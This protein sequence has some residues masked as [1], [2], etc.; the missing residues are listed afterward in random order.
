L[1][2]IQEAL[3]DSE[4][5]RSRGSRDLS[6]ATQS[7]EGEEASEDSEDSRALELNNPETVETIL[8]TEKMTPASKREFVAAYCAYTKAF[9]IPWEPVKVNYE[10]KEAF[11]PLESEIDSL[12]AGCG[13]RTATL[14]QALKDTAAR[15]GE[16]TRAPLRPAC[17]IL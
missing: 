4:G 15:A 6:F 9:R 16:M 3:N 7:P 11:S 5:Q 8:A 14:L 12:I 1:F 17:A 13:R 2:P 10:P